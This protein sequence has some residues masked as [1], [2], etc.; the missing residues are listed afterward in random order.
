MGLASRSAVTPQSVCRQWTLVKDQ[1]DFYPSWWT[2]LHL[3]RTEAAVLLFWCCITVICRDFVPSPMWELSGWLWDLWK[4]CSGARLAQEGAELQRA[5]IAWVDP[6][7]VSLQDGFS[8]SVIPLHTRKSPWLPI[9]SYWQCPLWEKQCVW[10]A[11][12]KQRS[13]CSHPVVPT[14]K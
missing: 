2:L 4:V 14:Y 10:T 9:L 5:L 6:P 11:D 12:W 1:L 13:I 7:G 8:I 3:K